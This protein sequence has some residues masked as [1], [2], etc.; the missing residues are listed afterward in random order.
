MEAATL[1][2]KEQFEALIPEVRARLH[3]P[4]N[5]DADSERSLAMAWSFLLYLSAA[6]K[7]KAVTASNLAYY[8]SR[9]SLAG[10]Q[11]PPTSSMDAFVRGNYKNPVS[12]DSEDMVDVIC[13]MQTRYNVADY[14]AF[15]IDFN[16]FL[17][18]RPHREREMARLLS[19]GYQRKEVAKK[20]NMHSSCVTMAMQRMAA[21]WKAFIQA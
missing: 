10:R 4:F 20:L 7:G 6:R 9:L 15:K 8:A 3:F 13:E 5:P 17:A 11:V 16:E 14:V 2:E 19:E 21:E 1:M 18:H 12:V